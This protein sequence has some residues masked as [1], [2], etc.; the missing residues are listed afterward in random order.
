MELKKKIKNK[1]LEVGFDVVGFAN[2]TTDKRLKINLNQYLREGR[3]GNM[4]WMAKNTDRRT[5]P[6]ELWPQVNSVIVLGLNYG[7][8]AP[9]AQALKHADRGNISVY[10]YGKDY[11]NLV[12][13]RLKKV[14]RWLV[15]THNC[16]IKV[17]VDTAPVMEKPLAQK[18][19]LGWQGKHTNLVSPDLGS[20]LFLGEIYTTLNLSPDTPSVD[21]CGT[22]RA[23]IDACPTGALNVPY[24]IDPRRCISYLTIEHKDVI[25]EDLATAMGNHIYG[26]DDCLDACPWNKFSVISNEESFLPRAELSAPRLA[27]LAMLDDADFRQVFSGSTIKRT[28]R[29]R[30][31]RNVI[32]AIANS[33]DKSL[34]E[35]LSARLNDT[36]A[37]VSEAARWALGRLQQKL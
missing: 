16:E 26:C 6:R 33:G 21:Q 10:A 25:P 19:G 13:Q 5:S 24:Q 20:W 34:M 17:F 23:C 31:V 22:C 3:Q 30:F 9:P 35:V 8:A 27:D 29:E 14:G 1:A 32:I 4:D 15:E 2:A 37:I 36:S 11:H 18:A 7:P 28:G 12:K